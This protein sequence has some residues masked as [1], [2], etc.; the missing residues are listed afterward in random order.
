[1]GYKRAQTL[2]YHMSTNITTG[3]LVA[4]L[5]G[6]KV[7]ITDIIIFVNMCTT[8]KRGSFRKVLSILPNKHDLGRVKKEGDFLFGILANNLKY[9]VRTIDKWSLK[10]WTR[11]LR[12]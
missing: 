9:Q 1:M 7:T 6:L 2:V 5:G 12:V 4:Q 11:N 10:T 3:T 8:H